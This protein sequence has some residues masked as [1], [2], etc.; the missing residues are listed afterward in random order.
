MPS[1]L[2]KDYAQQDGCHNCGHVFQR[3][4]YDE[5]PEYYCTVDQGD[6]PRPPCMSGAMD[7][8]EWSDADTAEDDWYLWSQDHEVTPWGV[9]SAWHEA[10]GR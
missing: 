9:C 2:P 5:G 4:L 3:D 1:K 10:S 7:D 8:C 6:G